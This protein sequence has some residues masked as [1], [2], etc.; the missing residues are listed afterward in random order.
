MKS[1]WLVGLFFGYSVLACSSSDKHDP[2]AAGASSVAGASSTGG[3]SSA[4]GAASSALCGQQFDAMAPCG[5]G[6]EDREANVEDCQAAEHQ[7]AGIGC[8]D[9]F[10][11]WV[12]CTTTP[13]Y[14]CNQDTGCEATQGSY[15]SCQ[16][17]AVQRTGCVHLGTQDT[18]RC[19]DASK[20]YAFSCLSSAPASCTQVVT[21]G[22]GIWC[23]PQ[24]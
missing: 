9:E 3:S 5:L 21:E 6:P 20:P 16:S 17:A 2:G 15:F 24:L 14:D 22:A 13:A 10:D 7:Y 4:G 8:Q 11:S 1:V 19:S 12:L 23:C 18:A